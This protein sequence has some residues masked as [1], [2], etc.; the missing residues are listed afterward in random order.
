M[1]SPNHNIIMSLKLY[2]HDFY[3]VMCWKSLHTEITAYSISVRDHL[4]CRQFFTFINKPVFC[5]F[6]GCHA[7]MS[8]ETQ[9]K[10]LLSSSPEKSMKLETFLNFQTYSIHQRQ[11][12]FFW[13][14]SHPSVERKFFCSLCLKTKQ[15]SNSTNF[16]YNWHS[17]F[18]LGI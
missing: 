15:P 10:T 16:F 11:K 5:V 7:K 9:I 3:C 18:E 14:N 17:L 12:G 2:N 6:Q 4:I 13:L 8:E 1:N